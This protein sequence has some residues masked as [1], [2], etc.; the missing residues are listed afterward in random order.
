MDLHDEPFFQG[1]LLFPPQGVLSQLKK[2][3]H[4]KF[5]QIFKASKYG[6]ER[7]EI[8][9][10]QDEI[11]SQ[12]HSPRILT[13]EAC[14]KI[15][16]SNQP[17]VFTVVT[18]TGVHHFGCFSDSETTNWIEAFQ[19]VAFKGDASGQTIE[20]D[21]DLY[22]TSGEGVFSVKVVETEA[23]KRCK[24]ESKTYTLVVAAVEM[25]IIDGDSVLYTW[26]YRYIRRY[27]YRDGKFTFEAGRKCESGEG[28]FRL[29]HSNQQEIF[30]C[31]SSKMK[32]MK[33]LLNSENSPSIECNDAQYHAAL[34]MEAGSRSPLPPSPNSSN[35]L[36]DID[37][38][39]ISQ[40]SQK[41]LVSCS[42]SSLDSIPFIRPPPPIIKPKPAKPPRKYIF[43]GLL[44]K[45]SFEGEFGDVPACGKYRKLNTSGSPDVSLR[46]VT[47]S[48]TA[49]QCSDDKHPYDLVEV[50]SDAWRTHGL[51]NIPHSERVERRVSDD[52]ENPTESMDNET[53]ANTNFNDE[54]AEYESQ[55]ETMNPLVPTNLGANNSSKRKPSI[56]ST[57]N[58]PVAASP[59]IH[60]NVTTKNDFPNYDKLQH[61][62]SMHKLNNNPGYKTPNVSQSSSVVSGDDTSGPW[63]NYD[64]VEDLCGIRLADDTH[65][66]Y[67]IIRKKTSTTSN[68]VTP[69]GQPKHRVFNDS[70]YAI[71]SKPKRV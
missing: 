27:G 15:S 11:L 6:I 41:H 21:N 12:Q 3:W 10:S 44:E 9:D 36:I 38:S 63:P 58:I 19:S 71:V 25:K 51:D 20:E 49:S 62:G 56:E 40:N 33:K 24:L 46:G 54:H 60:N 61:F 59:I 35:N 65:N 16:S 47:Q 53:N 57:Q 23:S 1:Q 34:S 64:V 39:T 17:R 45:K 30:R 31:I 18:K 4:K 14:I 52:E 69:S 28:S 5:C 55:Y 48:S 26:P 66:G 43:T 29:E 70:E 7:L 68:P 50:R 67:G 8:Y 32:S 37:F 42:S 2:T 13:L 22:C